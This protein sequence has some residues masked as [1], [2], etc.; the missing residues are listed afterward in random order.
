[1]ILFSKVR[2]QKIFQS[3]ALMIADIDYNAYCRYIFEQR[4]KWSLIGTK[5]MLTKA[6][7]L[8]LQAA[9]W[10]WNSMFRYISQARTVFFVD[11]AKS[12]YCPNKAALQ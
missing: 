5:Q 9:D 8:R 11:E 2:S 3:S 6:F 7:R 10:L 12:N 1:M 4:I